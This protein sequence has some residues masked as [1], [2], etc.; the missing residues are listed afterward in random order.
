MK[1]QKRKTLT[2][3]RVWVLDTFDDET[4]NAVKVFLGEISK[5][6]DTGVFIKFT[7]S[8]KSCMN[9]EGKFKPG[10]E[11]I[12]LYSFFDYQRLY[13][14]SAEKAIMSAIKIPAIK[15]VVYVVSDNKTVKKE[16]CNIKGFPEIDISYYYDLYLFFKNDDNPQSVKE[17]DKSIFF[18][19]MDIR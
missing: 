13:F 12:N 8:S 5:I 15:D 1:M 3:K 2:G 7:N 10:K 18:S 4:E 14:D 16:I 11:K 19:R 9:Y 17:I 6:D